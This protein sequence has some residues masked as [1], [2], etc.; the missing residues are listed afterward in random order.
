MKNVL[1]RCK[2]K[3]EE[4]KYTLFS[5]G[6]ICV[7]FA[8]ANN[9]VYY[10][11]DYDRLSEVHEIGFWGN[12]KNFYYNFE[13]NL[14]GIYALGFLVLSESTSIGFVSLVI[15]L[16][17][18][19][20][21][22]FFLQT[23]I[24]DN[25]G[26]RVL[27]LSTAFAFLLFF[28]GYSQ[29]CMGIFWLQTQV[30]YVLNIVFSLI[31]FS[32]TLLYVKNQKV[33]NLFFLCVSFFLSLSSRFSY[34]I[35]TFIYLTPLIYR[36]RN[37]LN[38]RVCLLLMLC[39]ILPLWVVV[40][41]NIAARLDFNGVGKIDLSVVQLIKYLAIGP[42]FYIK[43][44]L[45]DMNFYIQLVSL[46]LILN[47]FDFFSFRYSSKR[48]FKI[49]FVLFVLSLSANS[50]FFG[51]VSSSPVY[52]SRVYVLID[53]LFL[54]LIAHC[55][56]VFRNSTLQNICLL[57]WCKFSFA[58][59]FFFILSNQYLDSICFNTAHSL[60]IRDIENYKRKGSQ[61]PLYLMELP[62]SDLIDYPQIESDSSLDRPQAR[63]IERY[64]NL[65]F[66]IFRQHN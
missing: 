12:I 50:L 62:Q 59:M 23:L 13:F 39:A 40:S 37:L 64:Y 1:V 35:T 46:F 47:H 24:L 43:C 65:G 9:L 3:L 26:S 60:M 28:T 61:S 15:F 55:I 10:G 5:I 34:L 49:H 31:L 29:H 58:A 41:S 19:L 63:R 20:S 53:L 2:I 44:K 45:F 56:A 21:I 32:S 6:L 18:I 52:S 14:A 66:K 17:L 51:L 42:F 22:L 27:F 4:N 54:F 38:L 8:F 7:F 36:Y 11:D 33:R 25:D 48:F 16:L 57:N 30:A